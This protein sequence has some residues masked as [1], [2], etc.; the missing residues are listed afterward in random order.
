MQELNKTHATTDVRELTNISLC[1]KNNMQC[2]NRTCKQCGVKKVK[3]AWL[4]SGDQGTKMTTW[5][6]WVLVN[7]ADGKKKMSLVSLNGSV[8]QLIDSCA[9]LFYA[10]WQ[11]KQ[12]Q[13]LIGNLPENVLV[14][15]HDFAKN[16]LC[17]FQDFTARLLFTQQYAT[18][19]MNL[20]S[21]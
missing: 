11:C 16:Y 9:P 10:D 3:D 15:V 12:F 1:S 21:S 14:H 6:R 2:V 8:N 20:G 13:K 17:E 4:A 7:I 5:S 18:T 19:R